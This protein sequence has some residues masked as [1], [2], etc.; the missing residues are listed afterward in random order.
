MEK[1]VA[2]SEKRSFRD[3]LLEADPSEEMVERYLAE[4]EM[5]VWRDDAKRVVGEAV[6]D[7]T[8]GEIKNLA[9]VASLRG[10]GWGRA[11]LDDL[12]AHYRGR[13]MSLKVGTSDGGRGFYERCGFRY[14]HTISNFFTERYPAPVIDED[15]TLCRD[16]IILERLL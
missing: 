11:I 13:F 2:L 10:S 4:G 6:V 5:W 14:S 7:T 16:M 1:I 3:L 9:V 12:C 15:G 8:V